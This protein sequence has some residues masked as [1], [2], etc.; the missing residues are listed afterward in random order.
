ME[1]TLA[2]LLVQLFKISIILFI[3][4]VQLLIMYLLLRALKILYTFLKPTN[5]IFDRTGKYTL[6]DGDSITDHTGK[7]T[8]MVDDGK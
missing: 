4:D 3:I 2:E 1:Q 6:L 5:F 7:Y 8:L